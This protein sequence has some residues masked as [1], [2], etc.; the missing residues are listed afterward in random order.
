[1]VEVQP[2]VLALFGYKNGLCALLVGEGHRTSQGLLARALRVVRM[3]GRRPVLG[4]LGRHKNYCCR[5]RSRS[6][7]RQLLQ[8]PGMH[9]SVRSCVLTRKTVVQCKYVSCTYMMP[10]KGL[11]TATLREIRRVSCSFQFVVRYAIGRITSLK[12]SI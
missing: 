4:I 8:F 7:R 6:R 2:L 9:R 11:A 1:M 12:R 10:L 3:D 5:S